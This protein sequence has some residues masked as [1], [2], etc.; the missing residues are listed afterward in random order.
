M[1]ELLTF[2]TAAHDTTRGSTAHHDMTHGRKDEGISQKLNL[3][4]EAQRFHQQF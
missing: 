4:T 1:R 2:I 3:W